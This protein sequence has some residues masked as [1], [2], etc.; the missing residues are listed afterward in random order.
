MIYRHAE[1]EAAN[2]KGAVCKHCGRGFRCIV[3][4]GFIGWTHEFLQICGPD[5]PSWLRSIRRIESV[6]Q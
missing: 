6:I 5:I 2:T 4:A 3:N 1:T